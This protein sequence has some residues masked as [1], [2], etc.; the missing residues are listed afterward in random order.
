MNP[1][2][3]QAEHLW[4]A[5]AL[6][7]AGIG[8]AYVL[9]FAWLLARMYWLRWQIKKLKQEMTRV[10]LHPYLASLSSQIARPENV[11]PLAGHADRLAAIGDQESGF[12]T[13][14]IRRVK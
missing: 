8:I 9:Y 7:G 6:T 12:V 3:V 14:T 11:H 5:L 10:A 2:I 1:Q 4:I 13:T